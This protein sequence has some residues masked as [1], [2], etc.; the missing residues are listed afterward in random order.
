MKLSQTEFFRQ[1]TTV[2]AGCLLVVATVAFV[3][4]PVNLSHHPGDSLA[5]AGRPAPH[6]MT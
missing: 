1:I 4:I 3:S 5:Q 6:H 2:V